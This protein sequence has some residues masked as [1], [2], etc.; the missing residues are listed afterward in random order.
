VRA[1]AGRRKMMAMTS[2]LPLLAAAGAAA[3]LLATP[4]LASAASVPTVVAGPL[5]A[6]G[7]TITLTAT[8]GGA[9]DTFGI[10]AVKTSGGS[11]QMHSWSFGSGV[12]VSI[13][14]GKA[15][16][17]GSLG[18]Y[19]KVDATLK[20]GGAAKGALPKGCTGSAGTQRSGT[21]TGKSSFTLDSTFFKTVKPKAMKGQILVGGDITCGAKQPEGG[22]GL[23]LSLPGDGGAG[24]SA[25][26]MVTISKA[27]GQVSQMAM[28]TED[29]AATAPASVF[30]MIMAKAP[31]S[32]LDTAADL[33]TA[34]A[35]AAGP[36]LSGSLSFT[37]T[38]TGSD[39]SAGTASGTFTAKFD[40]IAPFTVP[41]GATAMLMTQ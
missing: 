28:N 24:G 38:P 30:H 14:G 3:A 11:T 16:I 23:T 17:K 9:A 19:G 40:S 26:T 5:K 27:D 31:A 25:S 15:T 34:T 12:K 36:F 13:K 39:M 21:V 22:K 4:A 10:D 6:K 33:S 1:G 20:A 41:A 8:D 35:A 2:R 18:K 37:G 7:Y 32:G 29:Q